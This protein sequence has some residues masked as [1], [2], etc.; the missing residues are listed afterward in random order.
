MKIDASFSLTK[1]DLNKCITNNNGQ[2]LWKPNGDYSLTSNKC[3][4]EDENLVCFAINIKGIAKKTSLKINSGISNQDGELVCDN[5]PDSKE[6]IQKNSDLLIDPIENDAKPEPQIEV[7]PKFDPKKPI[8]S[9]LVSGAERSIVSALRKRKRS[10]GF[11]RSTRPKFAIRRRRITNKLALRGIKPIVITTP[12]KKRKVNKKK[13][14][15]A[16]ITHMIQPVQ[17]NLIKPILPVVLKSPNSK[18]IQAQ[19][20]K[21][22][23]APLPE[24]QIILPSVELPVA[25]K[26]LPQIVAH[27]VLPVFQPRLNSNRVKVRAPITIKYPKRISNIY[28]APLVR[29]V[30][31]RLEPKR[32]ISKTPVI[33]NQYEI[34]K[35]KELSLNRRYLR[36]KYSRSVKR[37]TLYQ[38]KRLVSKNRKY[39]LIMNK[40]GNLVLYSRKHKNRTFF[41]T[42]I[43]SSKTLGK[44]VGPYRTVMRTDGNLVIYDSNNSITWASNTAG[45]GKG[46]YSIFVQNDGNLVIYGSDGKPTWSSNR[47]IMA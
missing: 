17:Q 31:N 37:R 20:L 10:K 32:I 5:N 46:P 4:L 8:R 7:I 1:I 44:G 3:K 11:L 6:S 18:L 13:F 23:Q 12:I 41:Y 25:K 42:P 40:D 34:F 35:S 38:S 24:P 27:P 45:K 22:I 39:H 28:A 15:K 19:K 36:Y 16:P 9:Q 14:I 33:K 30:F 43:W 21:V 26:E 29:K 47:K 2:L